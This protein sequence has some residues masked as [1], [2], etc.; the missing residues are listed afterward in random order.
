VIIDIMTILNIYRDIVSLR[1]LLV[2]F[3]TVESE[4]RFVT[5]V[6]CFS[7]SV[8]FYYGGELY[9][10]V[11]LGLLVLPQYLAPRCACKGEF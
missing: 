3:T 2:G 8:I 4:L 6:Y 11:R 10:G 7:L 9:E 5:S 1:H